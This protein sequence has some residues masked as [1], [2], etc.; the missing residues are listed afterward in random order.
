[1]KTL[2]LSSSLWGYISLPPGSDCS[3]Q[4]LIPFNESGALTTVYLV[5]LRKRV[6]KPRAQLLIARIGIQISG[7]DQYE[8]DSRVVGLLGTAHGFVTIQQAQQHRIGLAQCLFVNGR[9]G[10][11]LHDRCHVAPVTSGIAHL[12]PELPRI[13]I[14]AEM[15]GD[16]TA[17]CT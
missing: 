17:E 13:D 15:V 11:T 8:M 9:A 2:S 1:M 14:L 12:I 10:H 3:F 6:V 16:N 5:K 7:A 4:C